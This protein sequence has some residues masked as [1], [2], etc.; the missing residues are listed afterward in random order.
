MS[1]IKHLFFSVLCLFACVMP[2]AVWP[3]Q[4]TS[5]SFHAG[6]PDSYVG[7]V[8]VID[9]SFTS[10]ETDLVILGPD[11]LVLTRFY[12]SKDNHETA[13][14]GGW[15]IFPQCFLIWGEG[16]DGKQYAFVKD[17]FGSSL[18]YSGNGKGPLKVDMLE[19]GVGIANTHAGAI[20]GQ[21][22]HCN[23]ILNYKE[24]SCEL[25]LGDG[26]QRIYRQLKKTPKD[27]P[28]LQRSNVS[29]LKCF[30][31]VSE[32]LP[33]GNVL[34]FAYDSGRISKVEMKDSK[35]QKLHASIHFDY[36]SKKSH[37]VVTATTSD[38]RT[39]KYH[40]QKIKTSSR[41]FFVLQKKEGSHCMPIS[42]EYEMK[43]EHCLLK[44][45]IFPEGRFL[46]IEYN[47]NGTVKVLKEPS[48]SDQTEIMSA[49]EYG[50]GFTEAFN[51]KSLKTK[52]LYD[53]RKQLV[54]IEKYDQ[55]NELYRVDQKYW[56]E[57]DGCLQSLTVADGRGR[58]YSQRL[59]Q[60]DAFGNIEKDSLY[61][62]LT[63]E[64]EIFLNIE[65]EGKLLNEEEVE[66]HVKTYEYS[67][68][69]FNLLKQIGD[70]KGN[71]VLFQYQKGSNLLTRK[72]IRSADGDILKRTF[73]SYNTDGVCVSVVE[74][75][76][77]KEL[78]DKL[79]DVTERHITAI[80]P[81]ETYPGVGLPEVIEVKALNVRTKSPV[82]ISKQV[83]SYFPQGQIRLTQIYDD[84]DTVKMSLS[85]EY[86]HL[87]QIAIET[88][89]Q[90]RQTFYNYD[91]VGNQVRIS[92]PHQKK[93]IE[94]KYDL[95]NLCYQITQSVEGVQVV[96]E[97]RFDCLGRK[98]LSKDRFGQ[99]TEFDY[100]EFGR[101]QKVTHPPVLN[102]HEQL[103]RPKF[104]YTYDIFGNVLSV[105]DPKGHKIFNT[106]NIRGLPAQIHYP[107]GSF[108][109]F[110]YDTEG[111][112]H[113][114][115]TRD[116]LVTVHEYDDMGRISY[117]ETSAIKAGD[118]LQFL[119]GHWYEYNGFRI[120]QEKE[121]D[122]IDEFRRLTRYQHDPA[123]R[124]T[125]TIQYDGAL[126]DSDPPS[127]KTEFF[128][129]SLG[130][131]IQ[132]K[133]WFGQGQQDY[134]LEC[135]EY[136]LLGQVIKTW[137][138]TADAKVF[139][140]R[141]YEYNGFGFC[142]EEY[143]DNNGQRQSLLK[144]GYDPFGELIFFS[145]A[146]GNETTIRAEYGG[147]VFRK[148][149][150]DPFSIQT[151]IEFDALGRVASTT[152]KDA[153]GERLSFQK[154]LYDLAGNKEVE[155]NEIL[156]QGQSLGLQT[157]RS[158]HG[159]MNRVDVH[160]EAE[161]SP[162]EKRTDFTYDQ[163]G[164][165]KTKLLPGALP[166]TYSY[167][168]QGLLRK[169]EYKASSEDQSISHSYS[170][171][172]SG[173]IILA[174]SSNGISVQRDYDAFGQM[175]R[176]FINCD[177][178]V[179]INSSI[180]NYRYDLLGRLKKIFLPDQSSI[181][182]G[183]DGLFGTSVKRLSAN[184]KNLYQHTYTYDLEGRICEEKG[185]AGD[186]VIGYDLSGRLTSIQNDYFSETVPVNGYDPQGCLLEVQ[187][188]GIFPLHN[189]SYTYDS[190][191]QI[192]SEKEF[193][194]SYD[195]LCN[196]RLMNGEELFYNGL[197]Q[198]TGSSKRQYS[199]DPQGNLLKKVF[200]KTETKFTSD[201]FSRLISVEK[202][203][204][205]ELR[206]MYDPFGRRIFKESFFTKGKEKIPLGS[207]QAF[208][209]G[210]CEL[211]TLDSDGKICELRIPGL[212]LQGLSEK[213]V[214]IELG[215]KVY[216]PLH[217]ISGNVIALV[218]LTT[219]E[220]AESY[221]Y[222]A[223]AEE[224]I[225]DSSGNRIFC[226]A[227]KNPWQYKEKRTYEETGLICFGFR[228]YD[229]DIRRW[230]SQDPLGTLDG[231]NLYAFLHNNPLTSFDRLGLAAESD[232]ESLHNYFYGEVEKHCYCEQH[233]TC[234]RG[235]DIRNAVGGS[236]LG[237]ASFFM[238]IVNQFTEAGFLATADDF[239]FD[240]AFKAE[241][242]GAIHHSL[243]E[244]HGM[245]NEGLVSAI[246]FDPS[247]KQSQRYE[248]G[249]YG[250]LIALDILRGNFKDI[251]KGLSF[252]KKSRLPGA[253]TLYALEKNGWVLPKNGGGAYINNRWY[254][255][256]A[257]ERMAPRTPQ[258][259]AELDRRFY[260]RAQVVLQNLSPRKFREWRVKNA[261]NPRGIPPSVVEAEI[262]QPG[263][264]G[265][266]VILNENGHV[267]TI[268]PGGQ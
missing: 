222:S 146:E 4:G 85:K 58:V 263:S 47:E 140:A 75:D 190:L 76:G 137:N 16:S 158:K 191:S 138:E 90:G 132:K 143:T 170:Y 113:R 114:S 55:N 262:A 206:F 148:I 69:G 39:L 1:L 122:G 234:K 121:S 142:V 223:F 74:D 120:I 9:G 40:F 199:Y 219:K 174:K 215:K 211:G 46:Q 189:G 107:D 52:Y 110:K 213:S 214:A 66:K 34:L 210:Y 93:I 202:D 162:E 26:T 117:Q 172:G 33:S 250:G 112:L 238:Q 13:N 124:I 173:N 3:V 106:Y 24:D 20:N 149:V 8:S 139:M 154:H 62:N 221:Y 135:C 244:L 251:K 2:A 53:T 38:E 50:D 36:G 103:D 12:D 89:Q 204:E 21:T 72:L 240:R 156:F 100:D 181:S 241:M 37:Y 83:Y 179:G 15:N 197:N 79:L 44:K 184:K 45:Q 193:T 233:R 102:E 115:L 255:E 30:Q 258:V 73:Y 109:L 248:K 176:E 118:S 18:V 28:P 31:L 236:S 260:E 200:N 54:A 229:P 171:D 84:Q 19:D 182:Y 209:Y 95:R 48:T 207:S 42:Y 64:K 217:D 96:E 61:G 6:D 116:N 264:T 141:N 157:T 252:F 188:Q 239:G 165:L 147:S 150:T 130:R 208:Y 82:L 161:G 232:Q 91:G 261:P 80:Q 25:I 22:N 218:D 237:A 111:T 195:S 56:R 23:H 265:V 183:Y 35:A 32:K 230:I 167:N 175:T 187:R 125:A 49:F 168:K 145:D 65:K 94:K 266:R 29:N 185:I 77:S 164:R 268:I 253:S 249:A 99:P 212:S 196:C 92:V 224:K 105:T 104:S 155:I 228:Y 159:P 133:T 180:L 128:Y 5:G 11:P 194:S 220:V 246:N 243:D 153:R 198:L 163:Y 123:G 245:W 43:D 68:D 226:S 235:G 205:T 225:Y 67:K 101:L 231:P 81:R 160:I 119:K 127:R 169:I 257:L 129:D 256:H 192:T 70:C 247:S 227:I 63:G 126:S 177:G 216:A 203:N 57:N 97:Y 201:V 87:G 267:I 131:K 59:F 27:I 14:F 108:E 134:S 17:S 166:I 60:Y 136:D 254:T 242:Q 51:G 186:T 259:M 7:G 151:E 88:D 86:T 144:R 71:Q 78:A 98:I 178:D 10:I 152:K 41:S